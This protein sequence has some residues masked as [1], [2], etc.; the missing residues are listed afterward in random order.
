MSHST[1]TCGLGRLTSTRHP[2]TPPARFD[3]EPTA[4]RGPSAPRPPSTP[5]PPSGP[6]APVRF[7]R[8]FRSSC[9]VAVSFVVWGVR[10]DFR[11]PG[12]DRIRRGLSDKVAW[13]EFYSPFIVTH[14]RGCFRSDACAFWQ[15]TPGSPTSV[16][17]TYRSRT[18]SR[19][20][21]VSLEERFRG[22][23]P[24]IN[25]SLDPPALLNFGSV[26]AKHIRHP[27]RIHAATRYV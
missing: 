22:V 27:C 25:S 23:V 9:R 4:P 6:V 26:A 1:V 17:A 21:V 24:R 20:R 19:V 14:Y 13:K 16:A 12:R 18:A 2:Q 8:N 7:G 11:G 3:A 10:G 5:R 15:P